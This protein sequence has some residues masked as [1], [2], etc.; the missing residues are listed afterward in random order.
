[1]SASFPHLAIRS[2]EVLSYSLVQERT[3]IGKVLGNRYRVLREIGS[4]G[5]AWV[6]LAEDIKEN[7]QV[8]VKILYPQFGEDLSYIQR[9][10]REAK[11]ASTLTDPHIVKVLDYGADRDVYYLVME[12]IEGKDLR[13]TLNERGLFPWKEALEIIDQLAT[14][15]EHAHQHDVVHRDIKP[16]N[17]MLDDSGLLKVLDF[18]IARIPTLPSLTQ[19]G[20]IGSP[21]YVSPE[22]AMGEEVDIRSDIYSSGIVL[23]E[24]LSGNIPF[25]AKSPWSIISQHIA[26]DLPPLDLSGSDIPAEVE[27]L[28]QIM[29]AK[30]PEARF[31]T[32]TSLRRAIAA[33]LAGQLIPT[34]IMDTQPISP[35]SSAGQGVMA[36]SLYQR[37]VQAI[38]SEEWARAVD[39]LTQAVKFDPSHTAAAKKLIVAERQAEL[40]TLYNAARRAVDSHSWE[41]AIRKLNSIV[42]LEPDYR[43]VQQLL[44]ESL[45]ALRMKDTQQ[46]IAMRYNE[47]L[48]YF[49]AGR[50]ENALKAFREVQQLSPNFEQVE[51]HLVEAQ[52]YSHPN[53]LQK[54]TGA[55]YPNNSAGMWWRWGLVV[56]GII[57][58][59][60]LLFFNFG[61]NNLSV[62]DDNDVK[63]RLK[64]IY[65]EAQF[66]IE[67]GDTR[68]AL[69]LLEQILREDPDYADAAALKR[70]LLINLTP[71]PS[72]TPMP[73]L[74]PLPPSPTP[75]PTPAAD[76][77]AIILDEAQDAFEIGN[78][79][80][81]IDTLKQM[82]ALDREYEA[83]R[84]T[85]LFCDAYINRG[86]ETLVNIRNTPNMHEGEI[87]EIA[88]ADFEAGIAEC[89]RRVDLQE[90]AERA[91][92]YLQ[93]LDIPEND[94]QQ[95]IRILTPIVA[96][97]SN[98]ADGNAK[99]LLYAAHLSRGNDRLETDPPDVVGALSDYDAALDLE[100]DNPEEART[101][102]AE[103][104][105]ALT[106]PTPTPPP[107]PPVETPTGNED[108]TSSDAPTPEPVRM[109]YDKPELVVPNEDAFFAGRLTEVVFEWEPISELA[110]D[111]YY[112]LTVMHIFDAQPTYWGMAFTNTTRL[113]ITPEIAREMGF[114]RAG[115]DR[116]FWWVTIR[117]ANTAPVGSIDLPV[118][119]QSDTRT[120]IWTP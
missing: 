30:Q 40:I 20:F 56:A 96:A 66:A 69:I 111:E 77:L 8:A 88:L 54:L 14:A 114:G 41:E 81:V 3:L 109:E 102:R 60:M 100:V 43:D 110:Q 70:E 76:P 11:L 80:T 17:M 55:F 10:N 91:K 79:S 72:P 6:Y 118:S 113:L 101:R 28:M 57:A 46:F 48:S 25:D 51:R 108:E 27:R 117:K 61:S 50:W 29:V 94:Y 13:E 37:A 42:E 38:E 95:L 119:E 97:A 45:Q 106:R 52:R 59:F 107:P 103:L 34:E 65:E 23:Y 74:T 92:A 78:W 32:P 44:I 4:G 24:L 9:F 83:D 68:Q 22:Q 112:D 67:I 86:L 7:T 120:F 105:I 85:F 99:R 31:Q 63:Q 64:A 18:G 26:D 53:W 36:D 104:I 93:A 87:V 116:F 39:L 2:T 19:S 16:Q 49:Q 12:H 98:Y 33:V 82:R 15:L 75:V 5:M 21:Y 115:G 35:I 1:M 62:A 73:T 84:V 71:T 89:P 47:G 58:I 90:Q